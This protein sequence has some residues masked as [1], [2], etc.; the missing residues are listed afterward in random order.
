MRPDRVFLHV[1]YPGWAPT[2]MGLSAVNDGGMRMPP[3]VSAYRK[4][5]VLA[6]VR[7]LGGPRLEINPTALPLVAPIMR[8]V[9]PTFYPW[10]RAKE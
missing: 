4:A 1:V 2:E 6:R 10:V 9:V 8:T 5:G 7:R 3:R